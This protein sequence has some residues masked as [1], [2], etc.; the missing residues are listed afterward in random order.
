MIVRR[1]NRWGVRV[2]D[3][4]EQK[5]RWLGTFDT[6]QEAK[7]AEA[8]ATLKP[9]RSKPVT[10]AEWSAVWL[11]DY[12]RPAAATRNN[13]RYGAKR[14]VEDTGA[15]LLAD[16]DRPTARKHA[17][18]WPHSVTKVARAMFGD[19]T[20][21]GLIEF[22]PFTGLR[23]ETPRGRKDIDALTEPEI[24][25]LAQIAER[26]YGD[27][28]GPEC[29]A[30][31]LTLGYVG[32]RPGELCSLRRSDLD[33][34]HRRVTIRLN[35]GADGKEKLPKNGKPR[36]VALLPEVL[37]ALE[38]VPA[39]IDP[40]ARLF[41]TLRGQP[42]NKGNLAYWWRPLGVAWIAQGGKPISLYWLRHAC[43]TL[44]L[45]R[46]TPHADVAVQLGHTDGGALVMSTYGHQSE[47]GSLERI[48][49]AGSRRPTHAPAAD[50]RSTDTGNAA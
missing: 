24:H 30:I 13:Y 11:S 34:E 41:Y 18:T 7:N 43:A 42:F 19:A 48:D 10:V 38:R 29:A 8:R 50:R 20:R 21:D 45:E 27:D 1:G 23:I 5:M 12:V 49:L 47:R 2:W 36:R 4:R 46:G 32:L 31:I 25:E 26:H 22:N 14:V 16:V 3:R 9:R 28:Y 44:L 15:L 40:D 39:R 37:E 33:V 6:R 17:A 35:T